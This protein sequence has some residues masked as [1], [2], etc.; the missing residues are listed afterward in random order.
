MPPP[1][2]PREPWRRVSRNRNRRRRSI[3]ASPVVPRRAVLDAFDQTVAGQQLGQFA[4]DAQSA[5][6]SINLSADGGPTKHPSGSRLTT[7]FE[8]ARG[9]V[10][11]DDFAGLEALA[12]RAT[13]AF[14]S[15]LRRHFRWCRRVADRPDGFAGTGLRTGNRYHNS[16]RRHARTG[17]LFSYASS[18]PSNDALCQL[19]SRR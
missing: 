2:R 15:S 11:A 18:H 16:G 7:R 1:G 17:S 3:T 6:R 10:S 12:G 4:V 19:G 13:R 5:C 8:V 14:S 9:R